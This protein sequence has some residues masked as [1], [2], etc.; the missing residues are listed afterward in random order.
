MPLRMSV[1][2]MRRSRMVKLVATLALAA[3]VASIGIGAC[4]DGLP[5]EPA[6]IASPD[7]LLSTEPTPEQLAAMPPEFQQ[8]TDIL[9][10][11]LD[12][13]FISEQAYGSAYMKYLG[14]Y[15]A[16]TL[17]LALLKNNTEVASTTGFA[18]QTSYLPAVRTL[19]AVASLGLSGSCGHTVNGS[20]IFKAHSQFILNKSWLVWG[21]VGRSAHNTKSQPACTTCTSSVNFE[22]PDYDPYSKDQDGTD[23]DSGG[24]G[25]DGSGGGGGGS[26]T[27]YNPGDNTGGELV[28]W[29]T[30]IGIGGWSACGSE[31]VVEYICIDVWNAETQ[32]WDEWSCGYATTCGFI[33]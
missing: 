30:G 20:A 25:S 7:P 28:S 10:Y 23:C 14:N 24:D 17:P 27:Q 31:A 19:T 26:G 8:T 22:S 6:P 1:A 16:I 13:G 29:S 15:A 11:W 12:V 33:T 18:E 32:G 4:H 2:A 3:T 9:E 21:G 5:V